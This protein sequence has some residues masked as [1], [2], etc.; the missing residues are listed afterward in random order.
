MFSSLLCERNKSVGQKL[1][2]FAR[3]WDGMPLSILLLQSQTD[4]KMSLHRRLPDGYSDAM[5]REAQEKTRRTDKMTFAN[6]L[7]IQSKVQS[8]QQI[9]IIELQ[10]KI[11]KGDLHSGDKMRASSLMQKIVSQVITPCTFYMVL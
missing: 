10:L 7:K 11:S 9:E 1:V 4:S 5:Q 2:S 8:C 3:M 6:I